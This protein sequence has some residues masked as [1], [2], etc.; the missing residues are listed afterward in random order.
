MSRRRSNLNADCIEEDIALAKRPVMV[1]CEADFDDA[2]DKEARTRGLSKGALVR[3]ATA[4]F[5]GYDE[6]LVNVRSERRRKY[7]TAEE[8]AE[9]AK[10]RAKDKRDAEREALLAYERGNAAEANRIMMEYL[11]RRKAEDAE[12]D[13][14]ADAAENDGDNTTADTADDE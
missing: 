4:R 11:Q 6:S 13:A 5:I 7:A 10:R 14:R 2:I 3:L 9:A 12:L 8:R 1:M